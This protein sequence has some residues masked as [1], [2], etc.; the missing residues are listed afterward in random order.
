MHAYVHERPE[1]HYVAHGAGKLHAGHKVAHLHHVAAQQ[2]LGQLV[3]GVAARL[4]QLPEYI[5]QRGHA[6]AA[7]L[8]GLVHAYPFKLI[9][10]L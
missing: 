10:Q 1:V 3:P 6:Y 4:L 7:F 9:G 5:L 8:G 2:R